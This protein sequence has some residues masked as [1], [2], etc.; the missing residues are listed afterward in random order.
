MNFLSRLWRETG[1]RGHVRKSVF[2]YGLGSHTHC[3]H[4]SMYI[5][6]SSGEVA[7]CSVALCATLSRYRGL[8]KAQSMQGKAR[9]GAGLKATVEGVAPPRR[10]D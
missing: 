4:I 1:W 8:G 9:A 3:I 10:R 2:T 7:Q 5:D 6:A